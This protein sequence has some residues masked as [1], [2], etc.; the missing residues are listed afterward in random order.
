VNSRRLL[1]IVNILSFEVSTKRGHG[2]PNG[3]R[4]TTVSDLLG[5]T[6]SYR[7]VWDTVTIPEALTGLVT[8]V[9]TIAAGSAAS[10]QSFTY[11]LDGTVESVT[12][13]GTVVAD[14]AYAPPCRCSR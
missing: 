11:D 8:S 5:R 7:D 3:S 1:P 2:H 6:V 10:V 13:D 4:I 12:L 9:A 14:P